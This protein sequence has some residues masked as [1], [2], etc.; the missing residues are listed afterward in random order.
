MVA[1]DETFADLVLD[2]RAPPRL[3][4]LDRRVVTLGSISKAFWAGLRIGWIRAEPDLLG[5][6]AQAR[7]G[8]DLASPVLDQ[9]VAAQLLR[10]ADEVL[11]E[12]R[13]LLR[14]S[15]DA[16]VQALARELPDWRCA[17]PR[18]GMVLW[19]EL[20]EPSA[21]RLAARALDA[22]LRLTPGPRFTV[23]GTADRWFRLPFTMPLDRIDDVVRMLR[24][25]SS[26][27]RRAT[28]RAPSRWTA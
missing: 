18:A 20:P 12:R 26:M 6:L 16:L 5:R 22:G 13:A 27:S 23:D 21:T 8:Q 25:A 19:V 11:P 17:V 2:G 10:R 4:A 14:R 9:L 1:A 28:H 3:G 15:R 24:E 7:A